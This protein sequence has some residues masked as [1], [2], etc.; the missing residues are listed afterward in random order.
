M[1]DAA[2]GDEG[3]GGV[4]PGAG[5]AEGFEVEG[6]VGVLFGA[7]VVDGAEGDVINGQPRGFDG[8]GDAVCG[9]ADDEV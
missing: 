8:L 5:L 2:D 9:V 7:G 1:G 3:D 4:N 6:G